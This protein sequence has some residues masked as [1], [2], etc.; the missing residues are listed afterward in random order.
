MPLRSCRVSLRDVE[1]ITHSVD[2]QAESLFEAAAAAIGT[3]RQQGWA[4]EALTPRATLRIEVTLPT[5]VH[6]VPL[7]AVERW[8]RSPSVSPKQELLKQGAR[9]KRG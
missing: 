1:G 5:V 3:F 6:D 2:V 7:A 9:E 8:L 4:A